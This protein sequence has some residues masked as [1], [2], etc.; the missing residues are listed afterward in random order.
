[1]RFQLPIFDP[2]EDPFDYVYLSIILLNWLITFV[3]LFVLFYHKLR[4]YLNIQI[5]LI[6]ISKIALIIQFIILAF[7]IFL[8][9]ILIYL[10]PKYEIPLVFILVIILF[11]APSVTSILAWRNILRK[12]KIDNSD[13]ANNRLRGD[14]L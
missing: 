5:R 4:K 12:C 11:F 7:E 1:M 9:V 14:A 2:S 10:T 8:T 6:L 3:S 13:M